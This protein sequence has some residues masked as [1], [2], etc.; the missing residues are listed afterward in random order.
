MRFGCERQQA[1]LGGGGRGKHWAAL[2][3][4]GLDMRTWQDGL[5][6]KHPVV[7]DDRGAFPLDPLDP[8]LEN[9]PQLLFASGVHAQI[10]YQHQ[11]MELLG[12]RILTLAAW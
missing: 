6:V 2:G 3:G 7:T 10:N 1:C 9:R 8:R 4:F 12:N 5:P 11:G